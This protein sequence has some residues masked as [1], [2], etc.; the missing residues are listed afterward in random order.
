MFSKPSQTQV[1]F[2]YVN[3]TIK[4]GFF[5]SYIV[6]S[7]I[8]GVFPTKLARLVNFTLGK[9]L[10]KFKKFR[11]FLSKKRNFFLKTIIGHHHENHFK[12][13]YGTPISL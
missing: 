10:Y 3:D 4:R 8:L 7:K 9:Q 13:L 11:G 6:I 2:E 1:P 5:F 12:F